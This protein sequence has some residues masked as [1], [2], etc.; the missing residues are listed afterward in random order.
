M[1]IQLLTGSFCPQNLWSYNAHEPVIFE[2][3]PAVGMYIHHRQAA[4]MTACT[5]H[6]KV[7]VSFLVIFDKHMTSVSSRYRNNKKYIFK[8]RYLTLF[9]IKKK[10]IH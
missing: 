8:F 9:T 2:F 6:E 5:C 10:N 7:F 3:I 1:T 4:R